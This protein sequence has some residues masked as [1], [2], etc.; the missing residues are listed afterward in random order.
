M[1]LH[2]LLAMSIVDLPLAA[3]SVVLYLSR[4]CWK[5]VCKKFHRVLAPLWGRTLKKFVLI[6]SVF[7]ISHARCFL[8]FPISAMKVFLSAVPR[9]M[10]IFSPVIHEHFVSSGL[11][12]V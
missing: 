3:V 5:F 4:T 11:N 10:R 12:V 1:R 6:F 9:R 2:A 8:N 7:S